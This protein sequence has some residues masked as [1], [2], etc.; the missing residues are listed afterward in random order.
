[1]I[2]S[3]TLLSV[4]AL[5]LLAMP[6]PVSVTPIPECNPCPFVTPIP[7]CNPCPFIR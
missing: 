2:R 6:K 7:E 4:V 1:M 3:L 5:S